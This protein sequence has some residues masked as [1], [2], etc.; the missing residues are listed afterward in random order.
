[1]LGLSM[2]LNAKQLIILSSIGLV[3]SLI[4]HI[5]T[6]FD[7][8]QVPNP[9]IMILTAGILIV[10]L[11][12]SKNLKLMHKANPDQHPWKTVFTLCP[13]WAKYLLYFFIAYAILNFAIMMSF[14]GGKGYV[15][16]KVSQNKLSGLS[17]FWMVFYIAG[18]IFGCALNIHLKRLNNKSDES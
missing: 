1:M 16:F 3:F 11:Q 17:G 2:N 9:V 5:S 13:E 18:F 7:W 14:E 4:I 12:S 10:W 8:Y 6:V 15:N